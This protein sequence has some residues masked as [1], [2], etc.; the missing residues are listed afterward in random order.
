MTVMLL[1]GPIKTFIITLRVPMTALFLT[2]NDECEMESIFYLMT[3]DDVG[4][5]T[6]HSQGT[7]HTFCHVMEALAVI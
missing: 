1:T 2:E 7:H 4:I 3:D 6:S 5:L